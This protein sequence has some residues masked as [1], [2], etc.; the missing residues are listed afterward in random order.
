VARLRRARL[1]LAAYVVALFVVPFVVPTDAPGW[2]RVT[3]GVV[4]VAVPVVALV[5]LGIWWVRVLR[6]RDPGD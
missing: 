6:G 1:L 3:V 5:V 2:V 4:M